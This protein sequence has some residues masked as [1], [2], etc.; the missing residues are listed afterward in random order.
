MQRFLCIL[1]YIIPQ[2]NRLFHAV[3]IS[4]WLNKLHLSRLICFVEISKSWLWIKNS[5]IHREKLDKLCELGQAYPKKIKE[6]SNVRVCFSEEFLIGRG[7]DATRVY[8]G[9]GKDGYERAV[10]RLPRDVCTI[11]EQEK[12]ILNK[13]NAIASRHVVRYRYLDDESDV[14]WVFLIIDLCEET[15]KEYVERS[16]CE[17][18]SRIAR[19]IIQQVLKGLADLHRAPNTVLHRD[20][21][22]S[23]ILR[24]VHGEWLLADFGISQI[25]TRDENTYVSRERGTKDWRAVESCSFEATSNEGEVLYKRESDIQVQYLLFDKKMHGTLYTLRHFIKKTKRYVYTGHMRDEVILVLSLVRRYYKCHK[26]VQQIRD[27]I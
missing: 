9:L 11:A 26:R 6:I 15:L 27:K 10:K 18:L 12:K 14:D 19:S 20:L 1:I 4:N 3:T 25:L 5:I 23:N 8:V 24:N 22:P 13:P 21:K 2:K 7:S 16:D 17:K